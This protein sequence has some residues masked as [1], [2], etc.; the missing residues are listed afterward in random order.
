MSQLRHGDF[1]MAVPAER[2]TGECLY[3]MLPCEG[4]PPAI[5]R[6]GMGSAPGR[7]CLSSDNPDHGNSGAGCDHPADTELR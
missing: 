6:I 4:V 1:V 7:L 2:Y 3:V 5:Y